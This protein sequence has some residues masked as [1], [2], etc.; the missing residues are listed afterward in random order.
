[1]S[2]TFKKTGLRGFTLIE[3]LVVIAIIGLL[4]TII[5]APIQNARKK[6][7]DAKKIAELKAMQLALEQFAESNSGNYPF[8]LLALSPAYM[9]VLPTF[10]SSTTSSARDAFAYTFYIGNVAG[11]LSPVFAYH[12][13]AKLEVFGP[14]LETDR[15]CWGAFVGNSLNLPACV[16]YN[17]TT[18]TITTED[19]GTQIS[20]ISATGAPV[21]GSGT[22]QNIGLAVTGIATG[23][24][25]GVAGD[26]SGLSSATSALFMA[27]GGAED[28]VGT[29]VGVTNCLFDV[30][31]QQ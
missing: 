13:G 2:N 14:A 8:T 1:M 20:K 5:A 30:T 25:A 4:S 11:A 3:L 21:P 18:I 31:S 12:L 6:A 23:T 19:N 24:P 28:P 15:D 7:R 29:C 17:G 22:W 9:P 16:V 26:F 10:A 27:S